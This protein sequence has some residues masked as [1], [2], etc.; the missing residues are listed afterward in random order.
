MAKICETLRLQGKCVVSKCALLII[1]SLRDRIGLVPQEVELFAET[2]MHNIRYA[3]LDATDE[4]VYEAC[5]AAM[6]H[7]KILSFPKGYN[8]KLGSRGT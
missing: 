5:K 4:D 1:C 8:T 3:R 6:V 7:E 2:I